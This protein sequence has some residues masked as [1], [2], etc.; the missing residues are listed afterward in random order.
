[1]KIYEENN[2]GAEGTVYPLF[3]AILDLDRLEVSRNP[4]FHNSS[5]RPQMVRFVLVKLRAA[6]PANFSSIR[7]F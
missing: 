2:F 7:G 5:R 4:I 1:M 3:T 6:Y